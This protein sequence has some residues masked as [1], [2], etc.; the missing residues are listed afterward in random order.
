MPRI[1]DGTIRWYRASDG[2][3]LLAFFVHVPDKRWIAWT[4]SGY[5][6]ASPGGED[7]IGWH[8]NG[9]TWDAPVDFFPAVAVPRQASIGPTSCKWC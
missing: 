3:E 4:P 8:V 1:G 6:A 5:Y 7:L 9:K 2:A